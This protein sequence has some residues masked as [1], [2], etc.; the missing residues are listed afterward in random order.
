MI[1]LKYYLQTIQKWR[2]CQQQNM[3]CG[4]N[5]FLYIFPPIAILVLKLVSFVDY[6]IAKPFF[7]RHEPAREFPSTIQAISSND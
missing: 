4:T 2:S 7:Q 1:N 3:R 5:N 6:N